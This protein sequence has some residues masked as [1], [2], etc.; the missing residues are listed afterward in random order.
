MGI[1]NLMFKLISACVLGVSA[2]FAHLKNVTLR[3]TTTTHVIHVNGSNPNDSNRTIWH[4]TTV[5]V[6][7]TR[8]INTSANSTNVTTLANAR[9][10]SSNTT[11]IKP[12]TTVVIHRSRTPSTIVVHR[13]YTNIY[14]PS[15]YR[16]RYRYVRYYRYHRYYYRYGRAYYRYRY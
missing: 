5:Y 4:N 2:S 13:G 7:V 15:Y 1:I 10:S 8:H 14:R 12:S 6:N 11:S 3:N 16:Y 9:N